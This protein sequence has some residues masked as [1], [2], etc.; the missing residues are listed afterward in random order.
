MRGLIYK[1]FILS[2]KNWF[3][4]LGIA[5]GFI[6]IET[7]LMLSTYYGNLAK[8]NDVEEQRTVF[9][10]LFLIIVSVI[11]VGAFGDNGVI[12]SDY[13]TKWYMFGYTLPVS[14]YRQAAVK[15][16]K[17]AFGTV[18]GTI[19][20]LLNLALLYALTDIKHEKLYVYYIAAV[21]LGFLLVNCISVPLSIRFRKEK[22]AF[23]ILSVIY[24]VLMFAAYGLIDHYTES[25]KEKYS[26]LSE[27]QFDDAVT[28][29]ML[30]DAKKLLLT[31][32]WTMPLIIIAALTVSYFCTVR[33]MKRRGV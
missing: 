22:I 23:M 7:M 30:A 29:Q 17:I 27:E 13:K 12:E 26:G 25:L 6:A 24:A 21:A 31:F 4:W 1:E 19:F 16:G 2:R 14:E 20:S 32:G 28:S 33:A 11:F 18:A 3:I 5:A 15:I 9:F 8:M 10:S